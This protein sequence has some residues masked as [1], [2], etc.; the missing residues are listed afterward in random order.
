MTGI[1]PALEVETAKVKAPVKELL[2]EHLNICY[3]LTSTLKKYAAIIQQQIPDT[4]MD[5]FD[6][7][8]HR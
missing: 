8:R 1:D 6:L 2:V 7:L 5:L 3:L 4:R